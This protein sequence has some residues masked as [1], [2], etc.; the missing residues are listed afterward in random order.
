MNALQS[1]LR[2]QQAK[3]AA[4]FYN[5]DCIAFERPLQ[6]TVPLILSANWRCSVSETLVTVRYQF[7]VGDASMCAFRTEVDGQVSFMESKPMGQFSSERRMATWRF[8]AN[9]PSSLR[10]GSVVARFALADGPSDPRPLAAAFAIENASLS[11]A[12]FQ[13]TSS[14]GYAVSLLKR[15]VLAGSYECEPCVETVDK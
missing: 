15:R 13:L 11:G 5:V 9:G 1:Y 6:E 2:T 12:Q 8:D 7:A 3:A 4:A 10:E 14:L